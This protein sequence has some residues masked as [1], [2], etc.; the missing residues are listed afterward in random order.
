[1]PLRNEPVNLGGESNEAYMLALLDD[2]GALPPE[3]LL[4]L[5]GKLPPEVAERLLGTSKRRY[6]VR[7]WKSAPPLDDLVRQT[8]DGTVIL[9]AEGL[10]DGARMR[11]VAEAQ[12]AFGKRDLNAALVLEKPEDYHSASRDT[13]AQLVELV[14]MPGFDP[15]IDRE[16]LGQILANV[17]LGRMRDYFRIRV[18][19]LQGYKDEHTG[20]LTRKFTERYLAELMAQKIPTA[21]LAF[22]MTKLG[23]LNTALGMSL[24]DS[25][26]QQ[27]FAELGKSARDTDLF[28]FHD[29]DPLQRRQGGGDEGQLVFPGVET[30]EDL[31]IVMQKIYAR[32]EEPIS[33]SVTREEWEKRIWEAAGELFS[34]NIEDLTTKEKDALEI[35]DRLNKQVIEQRGRAGLE[36]KLDI[37]LGLRLGGRILNPKTS[38][39]AINPK[40]VFVEL[41][42]LIDEGKA[43]NG[44]HKNPLI[45]YD[46]GQRWV[47]S[48]GMSGFESLEK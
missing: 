18:A 24:T 42:R 1:M 2:M 19:E 34:K 39:V 17:V 4:G 46:Q 22:D 20:L 21:I 27:F 29:L 37:N 44:K 23:G 13:H 30:R 11:V 3:F 28:S 31:A 10:I 41:E 33:I 9:S 14:E 12:N 48:Q 45:L 32:L 6:D 38:P 40:L 8:D 36:Y 47:M 5:H 25:V 35:L 26:L 16:Q 7:E 43:V 15:K